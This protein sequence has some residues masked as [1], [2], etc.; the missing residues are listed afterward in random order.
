MSDHTVIPKHPSTHPDDDFQERLFSCPDGIIR[1]VLFDTPSWDVFDRYIDPLQLKHNQKP[2]YFWEDTLDFYEEYKNGECSEAETEWLADEP[3][4]EYLNQA[5]IK[6]I[7]YSIYWWIKCEEE[8]QQGYPLDSYLKNAFFNH[9]T[10][11]EQTKEKCVQGLET[12]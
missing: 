10:Y 5:F 12:H 7:G 4:S 8:P 6:S 1:K 3:L 11:F 2:R 9:A